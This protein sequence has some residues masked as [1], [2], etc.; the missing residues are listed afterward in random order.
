MR[1]EFEELVKKSY[2]E[3]VE[4]LVKKYGA[5][6]YDYFCS[7]NCSSVNTKVSRMGEGLY[8]HHIDEDKAIKLSSIGNA[9]TNPFEYQ[10]ADR[11]VYCNVLEHLL[12]HLK[13]VL[14]P[15]HKDANKNETHGIGGVIDFLCPIINDYLNGYRYRNEKN[16]IPFEIIDNFF[17]KY[18][19]ILR[20]F[21]SEYDKGK[22]APSNYLK[23]AFSRTKMGNIIVESVYKELLIPEEEDKI[24]IEELN[25]LKEDSKSGDLD[26]TF[27]LGNI[28]STG[29]KVEFDETMAFNYFLQAAEKGH[30]P[31]IL[32]VGISYEKG[33]GV[34]KDVT[35]AISFYEKAAEMNNLYSIV[36]L[37]QI[38]SCH[39]KTYEISEMYFKKAIELGF[40]DAYLLL[41][42]AYKRQGNYVEAITANQKLINLVRD[43][44]K[45]Q[46]S[47]TE[48]YRNL[49]SIVLSSKWDIKQAFKWYTKQI[50]NGDKNA[51]IYLA[52]IYMS[53]R[54]TSKN[55][56]NI[57]SLLEQAYL[58]GLYDALI[59]LGDIY[60]S[61][62]YKMK[63]TTK[64]KMYYELAGQNG[65]ASGYYRLEGICRAFARCNDDLMK[66]ENF[67]TKA[68]VLESKQK[69]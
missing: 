57:I 14:E 27:E 32:R 33:K 47:M 43:N 42:E 54:K 25:K 62:K 45:Y 22:E 44:D 3:I 67:L 46:K 37:G 63:N 7:E 41:Q 52:R 35:Q 1:N 59:Y 19:L 40:F 39:P 66:A 48:A 4:I 55:V 69:K 20:W 28:Y 61:P 34:E 9:R 31:S 12:L 51:C 18:I 23:Q 13:I 58:S 49:E 64:A 11:L 36:R 15:K 16:K 8:C 5:A 65:I 60:M 50:E 56:S 30:L 10:R 24:S 53:K 38:Y 29:K 17:E 6:R 21:F 2:L 68:K 26:K